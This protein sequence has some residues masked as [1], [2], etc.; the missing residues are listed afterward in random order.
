MSRRPEP[1]RI[2]MARREAHRARLIGDGEPPSRADKWV[3]GWEAEAAR[4]GLPHGHEFW[5]GAW[6]WLGDQRNVRE[7]EP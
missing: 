4:R 3:D 7:R 2:E 6:A 1:A 5:D